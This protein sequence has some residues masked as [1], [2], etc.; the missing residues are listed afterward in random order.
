M[1]LVNKGDQDLEKGESSLWQDG[2][3]DPQRFHKRMR[4]R[5]SLDFEESSASRSRVR[6]PYASI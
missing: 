2:I 1:L 4:Q 5:R 6:A 3:V